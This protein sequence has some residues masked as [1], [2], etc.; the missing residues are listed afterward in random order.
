[1]IKLLDEALPKIERLCSSHPVKYL[2]VFGSAT[3][4]KFTPQSDVDLLVE[5][6]EG[7]T[8][9][10]Y[11]STY[12]RLKSELEALLGRPVDLVT[13]KSLTNPYFRDSI[14]SE[15]QALYAA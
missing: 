8:A 2:A 3:G 6:Y 4:E 5:F 13:V 12:F 14:M 1:M 7:L 9:R 15:Q 10:E 11:A